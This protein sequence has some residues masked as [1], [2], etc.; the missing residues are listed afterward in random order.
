MAGKG[1]CDHQL[2]PM[3]TTKP[4]PPVPHAHI[5][6][7]PSGTGIARCARAWQCQKQAVPV[8]PVGIQRFPLPGAQGFVSP[9]GP[10]RIP[11][12]TFILGAAAP[13]AAGM[14]VP[15]GSGTSAP[16]QDGECRAGIPS[17][18]R[19]LPLPLPLSVPMS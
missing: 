14:T 12:G 13:G 8:S 3:V 10:A 7:T 1:L 18:A 19:E 6:W 17:P 5:S 2:C 16:L 4:Q 11:K 15:G 9:T